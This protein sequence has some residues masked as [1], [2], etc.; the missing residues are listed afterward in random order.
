[1]H[2]VLAFIVAGFLV[3]LLASGHAVDWIKAAQSGGTAT[4][5]PPASAL[6]VGA[7]LLPVGAMT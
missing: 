7:N 1:M 3:Y 2:N 6:N 5:A 4:P